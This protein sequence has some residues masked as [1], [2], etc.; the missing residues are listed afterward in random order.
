MATID[1]KMVVGVFSAFQWSSHTRRGCGSSKP[2]IFTR[3]SHYLPYIHSELNYYTEHPD[4]SG[5]HPSIS[6]QDVAASD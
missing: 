2:N 3:V 5:E 6:N 4:E 1:K